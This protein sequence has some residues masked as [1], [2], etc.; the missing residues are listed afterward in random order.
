MKPSQFYYF[1]PIYVWFIHLG[2]FKFV[3]EVGLCVD[4]G[5]LWQ[6]CDSLELHAVKCHCLVEIRIGKKLDAS[7]GVNTIKKQI[8]LAR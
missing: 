4:R 8:L 3:A 1:Q 7:K 6:C 5:P 2:Q